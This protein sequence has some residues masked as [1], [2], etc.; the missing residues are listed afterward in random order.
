MLPPLGFK[1]YC[2]KFAVLFSANDK[3]E[4]LPLSSVFIMMS[5]RSRFNI[6]LPTVQM[7][8]RNKHPSLSTPEHNSWR[9]WCFQPGRHYWLEGRL[10]RRFVNEMIVNLSKQ[11]SSHKSKDNR[12]NDIQPNDNWP[13]DHQWSD[14]WQNDIQPN[15]NWPNDHKWSDSCQNGIQP[16][17]QLA[18]RP[19]VE[20]H[21]V[22]WHSA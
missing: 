22:D 21:M 18:K 8:D 2:A 12:Q 5:H 19:P 9:K 3:L 6:R 15:D 14:I 11:S 1:K 13:N 20:W 16:K 17:W 4:C 10:E 7:L